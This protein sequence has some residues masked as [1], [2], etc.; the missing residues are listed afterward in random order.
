MELKAA[1]NPPVNRVEYT[2]YASELLSEL[3]FQK[4]ATKWKDP[5]LAVTP[6]A[7][8]T[9]ASTTPEYTGLGKA[10]WD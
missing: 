7:G 2:S 10:F 6:P 8:W 1:R 4:V 9:A 5:H 3:I